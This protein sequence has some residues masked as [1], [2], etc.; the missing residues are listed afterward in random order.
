MSAKRT[1]LILGLSPTS[2]TTRSSLEE[3]HTAP[4]PCAAT[5]R[6]GV[7]WSPPHKSVVGC[8]SDVPVPGSSSLYT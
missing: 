5:V 2:S 3:L 1:L 7:N 6:P 4:W 8:E